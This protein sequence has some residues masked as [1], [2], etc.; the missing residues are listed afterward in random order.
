[1]PRWQSI[2]PGGCLSNPPEVKGK[3]TGPAALDIQLHR[4]YVV[5]QVAARFPGYHP[6]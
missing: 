2:L 4:R 3:I 6:E 5:E 1:M